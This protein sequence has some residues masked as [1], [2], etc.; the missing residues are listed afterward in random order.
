MRTPVLENSPKHCQKQLKDNIKKVLFT[1]TMEESLLEAVGPEI[2]ELINE[3]MTDSN[4]RVVCYD[5]PQHLIL[6][7]KK[8]FYSTYQEVLDSFR[9]EFSDFTYEDAMLEFLERSDS[10]KSR[11]SLTKHSMVRRS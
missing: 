2:F 7:L 8:L 3:E 10:E 11:F 4:S 9:N 6:A 5:N 1:V